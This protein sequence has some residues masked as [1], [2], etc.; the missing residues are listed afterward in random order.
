MDIIYVGVVIVWNIV[1]LIAI[2]HH[3]YDRGILA[4]IL[5]V[6]WLILLLHR[7]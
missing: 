1:G 7:L 2:L 6:L 3:D 4:M 5:G